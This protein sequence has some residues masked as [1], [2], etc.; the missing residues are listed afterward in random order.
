M[1]ILTT[2]PYTEARFDLLEQMFS[3]LLGFFPPEAADSLATEY[4]K[5][6]TAVIV[7]HRPESE[8]AKALQESKPEPKLELVQPPSIILPS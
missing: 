6:R 4:N 5:R 3:Q 8:L 2:D 1:N 7:K